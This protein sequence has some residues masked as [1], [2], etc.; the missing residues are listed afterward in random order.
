MVGC[1]IAC[2]WAAWFSARAGGLQG[3]LAI[4]DPSTVI[5]CKDSYYVFG[6]GRGI[7][8]KS[9]KDRILWTAGPA[10]FT[11]P[12]AWAAENVPGFRGF[13]WAPDV[14]YVNGR[15]CIYY[16][17]STW[18]SQ[19]SAI[20]LAT[21][22]TL[23]PTDPD[24]S[25]TDQGVVI[26]SAKGSPYNTIDPGVTLDAQGNLWMT[27]GSFWNGIYLVQLDTMTGK[28]NPNN[29]EVYRLAYNRS[30][31]A[32]SIT[33]QADYYYLFVNWGTCCAGIKSTYNIRVGRSKS[34]TGP[35]LD[36]DGV[37]LANNG[38]SLFLEG[39][40][41]YT[42]PGHAA[43]LTDNG[44]AWLSYH[45]YDASAWA[46]QYRGLG[47]S[48]L[49]LVPIT[50]TADG[51]PAYTNE[52][53]AVYD[54]KGGAEDSNGEY[55][56]ELKGDARIVEDPEFGHV[57]DLRGT[58]GCVQLPAGIAWARTF[59]ALVKWNGGPSDQRI[60]DFS[61]DPSRYLVLTPSSDSGNLRCEIKAGA[62]VQSIEAPQVLPVG[63]WVHLAI[64][65]DGHRGVLYL[66]GTPAV[67]NLSLTTSPMDVQAQTNY[68]GRSS[69]G[70]PSSF[71]GLVARFRVLGR[72]LGPAE[73]ATL[74]QNMI[75][76]GAPNPAK[77]PEARQE[78]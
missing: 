5:K 37:D 63:R 72:A 57:L 77:K 69:S 8:S 28:R 34:I 43:V 27:F 51:W 32:P 20:G 74:R 73:I 23:D 64:T 25:W 3:D 16:S 67:T 53:S 9:S 18:G 40:G 58:N 24:Y 12:P 55:N 76:P 60:L 78:P 65:F 61:S 45:Y 75:Q 62:D 38:G 7:I 48:R 70:E 26:Q 47:V 14:I 36:R 50:W 33:R 22:P 21:N 10:V 56:G 6:T 68:L 11:N 2:L 41:K 54:F 46:G 49:D 1:L 44:Q 71:D 17:V 59:A 15:Y 39:T 52:W 19:V 42:G 35:Y 13:F 4:H 29:S 31:E 66:D 30:I